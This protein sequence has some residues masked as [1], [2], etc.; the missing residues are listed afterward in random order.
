LSP[1]KEVNARLSLWF[2]A[3]VQILRAVFLRHILQ[4]MTHLQKQT[5]T[6]AEAGRSRR[7]RRP[8]LDSLVI[9][10]E[11]HTVCPDYHFANDMGENSFL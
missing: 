10:Q 2:G 7:S 1:L 4:Y 9:K 6:T 3:Y 5:L 11:Q 8:L